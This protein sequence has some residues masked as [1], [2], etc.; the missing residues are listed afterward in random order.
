MDPLKKNL[1][2]VDWGRMCKIIAQ[3][4]IEVLAALYGPEKTNE[5]L[6]RTMAFAKA[7]EWVTDFNA[8]HYDKLGEKFDEVN[9]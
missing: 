2:E 7:F 1:V 8:F 9:F 6:M 3:R 4:Y 5:K